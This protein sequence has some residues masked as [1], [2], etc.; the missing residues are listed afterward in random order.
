MFRYLFKIFW[1]MFFIPNLYAKDIKLSDRGVNGNG[2][3]DNWKIIQQ[4]VDEIANSGGGKLIFPKGK[5][6][7]YNKSIVI[8]GDKVEFIGDKNGGTEIIKKG[9]V[10]YFGD[11]IDI[12]G[13]INGYHYY[14]EFGTGDY[15]KRK[16]YHGKTIPVKNVIL[17]N[18]N[19]SSDLSNTSRNYFVANNLGIINAENVK[20]INCKI[21]NAPQTNVAIVNDTNHYRNLNIS[22]KNCEFTGSG[23]HNVRVISYNKGSILGNTI[24]FDG[25]NFKN[26]KGKDINQK[27][28]KNEKL[29]LW[30]RGIGTEKN[31]MLQITN[32]FF[33]ETGYI[34]V[35]G[36]YANFVMSGST[37][38]SALVFQLNTSNDKSNIQIVNSQFNKKGNFKT[39]LQA[40]VKLNKE[41]KFKNPFTETEFGIIYPSI[42]KYSFR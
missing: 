39:I 32:C 31:N 15:D 18:I 12:A 7:I 6:A 27:E 37:V 10:G 4:A 16:I 13:K 36:Q 40:K 5:F 2:V 41:K 35:N 14:G 24:S 11:C 17:K 28:I 25:C 38:N 26:V 19:I 23:Q 22:F 20:I 9:N 34:F 30:Y 3:F 21:Q 1:I 33:D 8:W 42:L 29:N